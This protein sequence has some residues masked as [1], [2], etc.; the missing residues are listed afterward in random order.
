MRNRLITP[1]YVSFAIL[2]LSAAPVL[3]GIVRQITD[4]KDVSY[5]WPM[6][7]GDGS[8]IIIASSTNQYVGG[9]NPEHRFQ[10]ASIDPVTLAATLITSFPAS[11]THLR[12][13]VTVTDD[14]QWLAFISSGDLVPGQNPTRADQA[15]SIKRDGTSLT[16]LTHISGPNGGG[17]IRIAMAGTADRVMVATSADLTG[18]NPQRAHQVFVV[19][20]DGSNLIQV[21]SAPSGS[22][23]HL[24]ISDDG[25]RIAFNH[26][27][28]LTGGN[29]DHNNEVFAITVGD[30]LPRQITSSTVGESDSANISGDGNT[31]V[32]ESTANYTGGNADGGS[33]IFKADWTTG[34]ITQ[35][36][37]IPSAARISR[38]P[39]PTNDGSQIFF[40]SD[41]AFLRRYEVWKVNSNGTGLTQLSDLG[42]DCQHPVAAGDGSR[43][44]VWLDGALYTGTS[45]G[46]GTEMPIIMR[47]IPDQGYLDLSAN[48]QKVTFMSTVDLLGT[49]P[50]HVHQL[51]VSNVD[52]TGLRQLTFVATDFIVGRPSIVGD[53]SRIY[54]ETNSDPLGLNA[55]H[56]NEIFGINSDG[57]G[58]TQLT[59]CNSPTNSIWSGYVD[60]SDDGNTLVFLSLCN[61]TG[62][63]P[64]GNTAPLFKMDKFGNGLTQITSF[65]SVAGL[66]TYTY[67]PKLDA[68]GTWVSFTGNANIA[69]GNPENNYEAWRMKTDGT[70]RVQITS[71]ATFNTFRSDTS[72]DG[73]KV[74]FVYTGDPLG[75]NADHNNE[76]FL[77]E[78]AAAPQLRQLTATT[79]GDQQSARLSRDGRYVVFLSDSELL[80]NDPDHTFRVIYRYDLTT[81]TIQRSG[82]LRNENLGV[83]ASSL[84]QAA[85]FYA[86][87]VNN[88]GSV[89]AY[90]TFSDSIGKNPDEYWEV[91][92]LDYNAQN[93]LLISPH[94]APTTVTFA[95]EPGLVRYD[96]IR[97]DLANLH[98][99]GSTVDL[100][101]VV[102]IKDDSGDTTTVGYPDAVTPLPGQG[103]FYVFRGS[104]S[105]ATGPGSY[106]TGKSGFERVAGSGDCTP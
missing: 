69:G 94:A 20:R 6:P 54:F 43:Y 52:G 19:K 71:S 7:I 26:T 86:E 51:F 85:G 2:L 39:W 81:S 42:L 105:I 25:N 8:E 95:P 82:G 32:F 21:T 66:T 104:M 24:W 84:G 27:G 103:F 33:E 96:V 5:D 40:S 34:T 63:N 30:A 87:E 58:L 28:D 38:Q 23:D 106:G 91:M 93:P 59:S 29:P 102:C 78:P 101:A 73:S 50:D 83:A 55:D 61:L 67:Y 3:A 56:N 76:V 35:V 72:G 90:A 41:R 80:E 45:A 74:V 75:T 13:N 4:S 62:S 44:A 48:G 92:T 49:N 11:L 14:G 64:S 36:T 18:G 47:D 97:G 16:Q 79:K 22:I 70:N 9:G 77:Y 17:V 88:D 53:G 68:T 15:F 89:V 10:I 37:S 65:P 99:V 31:I 1:A 100:G 98:N 46:I 60:V 12:H 57:T